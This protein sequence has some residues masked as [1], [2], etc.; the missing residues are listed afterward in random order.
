MIH[1]EIVNYSS[2]R[3]KEIT[4]LFYDSVHSID[5]AIYSTVQ[6]NTW[7][8][9][10]IN[11][12]NWSERLEQKRPYLL[13]IDKKVAGFIELE[14]DGHIDCAYVS[15]AFQ[16]KGVGTSLLK[17]VINRAK[18]LGLDGLYVEASIVAKPL[19]QKFGFVQLKENKI[20]K[21]Q[22]ELINYSMRLQLES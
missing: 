8:S 5:P 12:K 20:I 17:F 22:V 10:P 13:L 3:A 9:F 19:F 18:E 4:E 16:G 21:N 2:C 1:M 14:P 15:P 6:K 11:Y 7:A